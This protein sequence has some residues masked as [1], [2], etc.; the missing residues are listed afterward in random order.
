MSRI[1]IATN[2]A[3]SETQVINGRIVEHNAPVKIG[4]SGGPLVDKCGTLFDAETRGGYSTSRWT[5]SS[6]PLH[7]ISRDSQSWTK[8]R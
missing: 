3:L 4:G 7:P 6:S 5:W 8:D 1:H 2:T